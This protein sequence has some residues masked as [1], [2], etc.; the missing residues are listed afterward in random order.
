VEDVPARIRGAKGEKASSGIGM[1]RVP[2]VYSREL[3]C[4]RHVTDRFKFTT[5]AV[6]EIAGRVNISFVSVLCGA[7]SRTTLS[8]HPGHHT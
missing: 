4:R 1:M 3:D 5:V 8:Q 6:S 2:Q 7:V